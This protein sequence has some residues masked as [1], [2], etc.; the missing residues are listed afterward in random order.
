VAEEAL[1][2]P[3]DERGAVPAVSRADLAAGK[4]R[5]PKSKIRR[6]LGALASLAL[7]VL[8]FVG[9]IPQFASYQEAWTAISSMGRWWWVAIIAVAIVNQLSYV[10]PYQ[11]ALPHLRFRHGFTETQTTTAISNTVPAGGAVA[12]GMTF[13]MFESFSFSDVAI[14]T[15]VAATGV[16]NLAFKFGPPIVAVAL[17]ASTGQSV[18]GTLGAALVGVAIIVISVIV[19]WLTFRSET[20]A[21][22]VGHVGD[23]VANWVLHFFHK[24]A[25]DQVERSVLRFRGQTNDIVHDRGWL[26]TIAVVASQL[27][28]FALL[29]VSVR[30]VGIG[31][32]QVGFVEVLLSFAVARLAGAIPI[33]PGG[34][35]TV[36]AALIGMLTAFGASSSDALAADLVWR[37]TS[38]LPPIFIGLVAYVVW[39]R[40]VNKSRQLDDGAETP[41]PREFAG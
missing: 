37:A 30:A 22:W 4:A 25:S 21:R 14:S 41:G 10:W 32:S 17:V 12:I 40:E 11:A 19:L 6:V 16:W 8:I 15:A 18:G 35:G 13:R 38:Y 3:N 20:S 29:L 7:I 34:L 9:V 2:P 23:R 28:V 39:T 31:S 33:T 1:V 26:L 24:D 36:D 5:K 27:A